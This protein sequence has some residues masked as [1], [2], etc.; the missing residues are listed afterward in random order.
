MASLWARN[1]ALLAPDVVLLC[2]TDEDLVFDI[3]LDSV[4][5]HMRLYASVNGYLPTL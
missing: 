4:H 5:S 3:E 1:Y 2:K